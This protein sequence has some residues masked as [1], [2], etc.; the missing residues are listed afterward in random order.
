MFVSGSSQS[1]GSLIKRPISKT[2][3]PVNIRM[4]RQMSHLC[5]CLGLFVH[6]EENQAC[7]TPHIGHL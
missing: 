3:L 1:C 4:Q 2:V 5:R 6:I 7:G